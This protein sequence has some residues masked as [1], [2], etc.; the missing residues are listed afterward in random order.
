MR[1]LIKP[2]LAPTWTAWFKKCMHRGC[3]KRHPKF[4]NTKRTIRQTIR[5]LRDQLSPAQQKKLS[6]LITDHITTSHFFQKSQ[7][8][9]FYWPFGNEVDVRPCIDIALSQNK[10]CY[11]PHVLHKQ[12]R[13]VFLAY[14]SNTSMIV[15]QYGILE[16][17]YNPSKVM[18]PMSLDC[19]FLPLIAYDAEGYRLGQGGG[20]Y[21][22]TFKN[23]SQESPFLIGLA[24]QFQEVKVLPIDIWDLKLDAV[25]TE[26]GLKIF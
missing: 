15:N 24:Y 9:G 13:L 12:R 11:L 25:I 14:E 6:C 2:I 7:T 23:G 17:A 22:A 26:Y 19:V 5:G 3:G 20:Y 4:M 1:R 21:D 8:I 18:P 10:I 16:P